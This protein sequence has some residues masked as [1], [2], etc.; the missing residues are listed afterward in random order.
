MHFPILRSTRDITVSCS[1]RS[2]LALPSPTYSTTTVLCSTSYYLPPMLFPTSTTKSSRPHTL[3]Q[4]HHVCFRSGRS[5][6]QPNRGTA[7]LRLSV[8][9]NNTIDMAFMHTRGGPVG[10]HCL[11]AFACSGCRRLTSPVMVSPPN[12]SLCKSMRVTPS[13][14][15]SIIRSMS[16]DRGHGSKSTYLLSQRELIR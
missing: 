11:L 15:A 7:A 5:H 4:H 1:C 9:R 13:R 12:P 8:R 2:N 14:L 6:P 3:P 10:G 16:G